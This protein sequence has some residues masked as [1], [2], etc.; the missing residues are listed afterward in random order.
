[1]SYHIPPWVMQACAALVRGCEVEP[2][3]TYIKLAE[4]VIGQN[5]ALTEQAQRNR[6]RLIE[7]VKFSL[8]NRRDYPFASLKEKYRFGLGYN[9]FGRE[10]QK[11]CI[12]LA[13]LCRFL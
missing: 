6:Q 7:A 10:K 3:I 2:Y 13:R 1:M 5:Y 4:E 11:F 8:I 9:A 12:E